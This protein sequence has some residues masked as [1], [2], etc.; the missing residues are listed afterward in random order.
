MLIDS[1]SLAIQGVERGLVVS[2]PKPRYGFTIVEVLVAVSIVS[3]CVVSLF[4]GISSGVALIG[5]TREDMRATQILL[6]Q[7]ETVRLY[8]WQQVTNGTVLP[9][10]FTV[11]QYPGTS[12]EGITYTGSTIVED[13]ALATTYSEL[14]RKVVATVTWTVGDMTKE[15]TMSTLVARDGLHNYLY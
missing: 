14:T 3:I 15:R 6:E 13:A 1:N 5:W 7:M 11:K 10:S 12:S 9:A 8:S 4:A 2:G